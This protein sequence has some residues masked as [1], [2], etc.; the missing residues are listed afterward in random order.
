V[1]RNYAIS[2][3]QSP[4]ITITDAGCIPESGWLEE[5]VKP[6]SDTKTQV[7]SGYYK[8]LPQNIFQKC[9]IPYVLVMPDKAGKTE[10]FPSTRSMAIRRSVWDQSGGFDI[11]LNHNE[12]YAY[13]HWLKNM[14]IN[15]IFVSKAVVGWLPRKNLLQT[16]WMFTRFAIGDVQSKIIRPKVKLLFVRYVIFIY[17]FM[18]CLQ[19][20][21]LFI[22]L[23]IIS[24]MYLAW[25][26]VKNYRYVRHPLAF[27][28]LPVL[29]LTADIS[30]MF[31]TMVGFMAKVNGL[32]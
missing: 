26:T 4:I 3:C 1:G 21:I 11:K 7:V 31:G 14:G 32:F 30:V 28:W 29:Q 23:G 18:L 6:F 24:L 20:N 10:F 5:I 16:A 9:L 2:H 25:S 8:G 19:I 13:A 12:D 27:F 22:P 15:S 17:L